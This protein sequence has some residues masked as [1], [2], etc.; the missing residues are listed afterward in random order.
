MRTEGE[1]LMSDSAII[2]MTESVYTSM[3]NSEHTPYESFLP[4]PP[5]P[6]SDLWVASFYLYGSGKCS[7]PKHVFL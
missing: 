2:K 3:D 7:L 1:S 6:L 4:L 5:S